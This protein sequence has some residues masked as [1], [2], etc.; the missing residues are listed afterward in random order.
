M[1][2]KKIKILHLIASV[3]IGGA[4]RVLLTLLKNIDRKKFDIVLG[5]FTNQRKDKD[6]LW[7]ECEKLHITLEQIRFKNPYDF[8]Q[9]LHIYRIA[10]KH[11]PDIMHTHGYK[12]NILGFLVAKL[13]GIPIITTVHGLYSIRI[14]TE[15]PLQLSLML[16]RYFNRVI[17]VSDYITAELKRKKVPSKKIIT[18]RNVPADNIEIY[19]LNTSVFREE[20]GISSSTKII[21]FVGRLE[22]VKGCDQ[23]I[24]AVSKIHSTNLEFCLVVVGEGPERESLDFLVR[25]LGLRN[26]VHFCGFRNDP[27]NVFQSLDLFVL[28]SLSEGIPLALLEAMSLGVPVVATHVGGVPEVIKNRLNGILV[29]PKDPE[30]LAEAI[31]ESLSRP[32]ETAKR[33]LEAKK[34]IANGFNTEKWIEEIQNIY[35]EMKTLPEKGNLK[36]RQMKMVGEGYVVEIDKIERGEWPEVLLRFDDAA[37]NQTWS[38]GSVRWGKNNLS[39]LI[40]KREGMILAAA[41]LRIVRVPFLK[42]GI[43][44]ISWGPMWRLQGRQSDLT[45]LQQML[46]ALRNEYAVRR[47]LLLR[48]RLNVYDNDSESSDICTMI[49]SEGFRWKA[50]TYRTLLLDLEP[51]VEQL[52]MNLTKEWRKNLK[53]A[54]SN[55]LRIIQGTGDELFQPVSILYR[56][57]LSRKNFASGIDVDQFGAIQ[58]DLPDPLKMRIMLCEFEG[59]PIAALVSSNLGNTGIELVAATADKALKLNASYLL[60]WQTVQWL[61]DSGCQSY[62][63]NG[64]DPEMNPGGYQ[65]KM[66]LAGKVGKDV[67]YLGEFEACQSFL[68]SF[69]VRLGDQLKGISPNLKH[70]LKKLKIIGN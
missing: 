54:E 35:S 4:E 22:Q 28:P 30:A 68:S 47:G 9:I 41:Q 44:Y 60:R 20:I 14:K 50:S 46:R 31:V 36:K 11:H 15:I 63:L 12:T 43:A 5:I 25:K 23:L 51:S 33:G 65:F 10:K 34:T 61:K 38:Y 7:T 27:I 24:Q 2:S 53:K 52:R 19:P 64:I 13:S 16:L 62:D 55:N 58:K 8:L 42:A 32:H 48:I 57:L 29:P 56:E 40:L 70:T 69:L 17:A 49:E 6:L 66:G 21:G 37:I 39:H 18:I 26:N 3:G 45:H 1:D 59:K 67:R